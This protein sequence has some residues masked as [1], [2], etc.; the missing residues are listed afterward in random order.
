MKPHMKPDYFHSYHPSLATLTLAAYQSI[1][2]VGLCR[3]LTGDNVVSNRTIFLL[4][5]VFSVTIIVHL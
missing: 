3:L 2:V 1:S 5:L 4:V